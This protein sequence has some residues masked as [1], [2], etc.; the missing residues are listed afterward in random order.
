MGPGLCF[1][2]LFGLMRRLARSDVALHT[3]S[4]SL[5][6]GKKTKKKNACVKPE[7]KIRLSILQTDIISLL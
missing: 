7:G 3:D 6:N 2:L 4:A 5:G 1:Q